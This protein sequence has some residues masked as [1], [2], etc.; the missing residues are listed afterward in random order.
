RPMLL[1]ATGSPPEPAPVS[2]LGQLRRPASADAWARF[3]H[4]YTPVLARWAD[5]LGGPADARADL[6]QEVFLV[7]L[8]TLPTFTYDPGRSFRGWLYAVAANKWRELRRKRHPAPL[9]APDD[10]AGAGPDPAAAVDEAEYRAVVAARAADLIRPE[11]APATWRAFWD[12]GRRPR[13]EE[14]TSELQSL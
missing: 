2:L 7:L 1:P 9:D 3:A 5:R 11:F 12:R 4:L 13:S 14:H 10:L 8:R 6:V